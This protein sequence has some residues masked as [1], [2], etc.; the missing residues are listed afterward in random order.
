M[1]DSPHCHCHT[2]TYQPINLVRYTDDMELDDARP[3][4]NINLDGRVGIEALS[5]TSVLKP[6]SQSKCEG[7]L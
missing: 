3:H 2:P 6:L 4:F 5:F 1:R 7:S